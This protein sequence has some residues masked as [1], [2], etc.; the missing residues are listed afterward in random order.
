MSRDEQSR[1]TI[2]ARTEDAAASYLAAYDAGGTRSSQSVV[3]DGG[4]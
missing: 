4:G 3:W 1:A 2:K